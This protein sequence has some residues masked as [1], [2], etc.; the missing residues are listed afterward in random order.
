L[1]GSLY[2]EQCQALAEPPLD[3]ALEGQV[4]KYT[5]QFEE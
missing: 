4:Q 1:R 5:A 3:G 2:E